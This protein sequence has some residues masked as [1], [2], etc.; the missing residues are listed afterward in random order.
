MQRV[1]VILSLLALLCAPSWANA[2]RLDQPE[3]DEQTDNGSKF[4]A[5]ISLNQDAFFGFWPM[6]SGAYEMTDGLDFTFYSI[7]WTTP[8]F[9]VGGGTGLWTEFGVG[10]SFRV[11]DDKLSINPQIGILNGN[12]LSGLDGRARAAEGLVPNLTVDYDDDI[13]EAEL[14]FG[15]YVGVRGEKANRLDYIHYWAYAGV[16]PMGFGDGKAKDLLTLGMHWEQLRF[17]GV[18]SGSDGY[19]LYRWIG[20]YVQ[21]ALPADVSLRF[22]AGANLDDDTTPIDFYKVSIAMGF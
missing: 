22:S 4:S 5:N 15:Y 10:T 18:P 16:K 6:A 14:Y 21:F 8:S 1:N 9:G 13:L 3:T 12:L 11:L 2:Q 19:N 17:T 20:P 7:V